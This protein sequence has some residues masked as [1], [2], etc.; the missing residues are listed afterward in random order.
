MISVIVTGSS[1][2]RGCRST[3]NFLTALSDFG[4]GVR[5]SSYPE[6]DAKQCAAP[7]LPFELESASVGLHGPATDRQPKAEAAVF[8]SASSVDAI[9]PVE[10]AS[11]LVY[12]DPGPG[13]T[14]LDGRL[15]GTRDA[16]PDGDRSLGR[17]VFV[18]VV[19][20]ID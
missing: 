20:Q 6:N 16:H 2:A 13:I 9:E 7:L 5:R 1:C 14:D 4:R 15:T 18:R 3:D 11:L 10:D 12:R 17:R 8:A 19:Q